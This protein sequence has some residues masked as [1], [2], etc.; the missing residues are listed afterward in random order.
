MP[1]CV[2]RVVPRQG[3]AE[4]L[5]SQTILQREEPP[6][7]TSFSPSD[8]RLE[9]TEW[10]SN[11]SCHVQWRYRKRFFATNPGE[12]QNAFYNVAVQAGSVSAPAPQILL[13]GQPITAAQ[14]MFSQQWSTPAGTAIGGYTDTSG[15]AP[16]LLA[17]ACSQPDT[18]GGQVLLLPSNMGLAYTLYWVDA[19]NSR[20]I[21]Y[22]YTMSNSQGTSATNSAT[23]TFDIEGPTN[24]T[25][26]ASPTTVNILPAGRSEFP[27][28]P[29]LEFGFNPNWAPGINFTA[30]ATLPSGNQG[31]YSFAQLISLDISGY[32][33]STPANRQACIPQRLFFEHQPRAR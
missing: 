4:N 27:G 12:P 31:S 25:M 33:F 18:T 21:T 32:F 3:T 15:A 23:A 7:S 24:A 28:S 29:G 14:S 8:N 20:Q 19:G 9:R 16:C 30:S 10:N 13:Y 2:H 17:T 5:R 11:R 1:C 6:G 22:T 26:D